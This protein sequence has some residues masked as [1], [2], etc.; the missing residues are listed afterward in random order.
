MLFLGLTDYPAAA[1][2]T[3]NSVQLTADE[4]AFLQ[5]LRKIRLCVGPDTLPLESIEDGIHTGMNAEYMRIFQQKL[6]IPIE[7][8]PTNTWDESM[9]KIRS[10][11]CNIISLAGKT[12]DREEFLDFTD[13]YISIPLVVV[14]TQ[15][16]FF[17]SRLSTLADKPL[18]VIRGYSYVE[19]LKDRYPN[20]N[21]IQVDSRLEGLQKVNQGKLYGFFSGLHLAGYAIQ[22]HGFT[23]LK[24]NGQFDELSQIELGIGVRQELNSLVPIFNKLIA[25]IT[26]EQRNR[27]NNSWRRV[28][29]DITESYTRILL[30]LSIAVVVISSILLWLYQTRRHSKQLERNEKIIWRQA[31]YD[32]LTQLPNRR[33]FQDRLGQLLLT[34]QRTPQ[35]FALF[36]IDLDGFKEVN[37]SM[38]HD[39]GDELLKKVT[40]RLLSAL[41][42]SDSLARLGGD[43]FV[44]IINNVKDRQIVES[45]AKNILDVLTDPFKMDDT[46]IFISASLG[47][48]LF[49][50]D[51]DE[52]F[53]LS[54]LLKNADQAM[55][56]AKQQ[57]KN[58]FHYFTENM[59]KEALFRLELSNDLRTAIDKNE[60]SLYYQPILNIN[61]NKIEKAEAL[62]R[63]HS[64]K[65]G[66]VSPDSFIPLLEETRLITKLGDA[67][68]FEAIECAKSIEK[69][70]QKKI[71]ISLNISPVQFKFEA[72]KKWPIQIKEHNV[73][74]AIEVTE[75]ILMESYISE[76]LATLRSKGF[77]ISLDDFG[78]GYSSLSYLRQFPIDCLKIDRSFIQGLDYE[79]DEY[80]LCEAIT[81]MAHHLR[82]K[83]VA[84]GVETE[85]QLYLLNDLNVDFIQGYFIA[86]PMP[87]AEF[88]E[89]IKQHSS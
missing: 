15:E 33:L 22:E 41:R 75:S 8:Q 36:L 18:G 34:H 40:Q 46:P 6:D 49:P 73:K 45:V 86:K 60:F 16:K 67:L 27:I 47:I 85:K 13:S 72:L 89:F 1:T 43:E 80:Y 2:Q 9:K 84:E 87:K 51:Y 64:E 62:V 42:E 25:Q 55:Y 21:L 24:I 53:K 79:S 28:K 14:T 63:W 83:V 76:D 78:V 30:I 38:G 10:G 44:A 77:T 81:N 32:F 4:Q 12:P 35:R 71:E 88:L 37:D 29:F 74:L 69:S 19:L 39:V 3:D 26:T 66:L 48:T 70:I 68:F 23:N 7:L 56:A 82:L 11:E 52:H 54:Q 58:Q 31:H 17:V 65:R 5:R 59:N 61:N 57:G 20:I 50:S